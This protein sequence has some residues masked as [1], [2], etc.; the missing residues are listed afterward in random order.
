MVLLV[1]LSFPWR[2]LADVGECGRL[3]HLPRLR[4]APHLLAPQHSVVIRCHLHLAPALALAKP[5]P[6]LGL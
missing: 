3:Q 6:G 2:R 5:S 1:P 4:L